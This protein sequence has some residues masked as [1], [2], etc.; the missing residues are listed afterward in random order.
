MPPE[1][2][3]INT[4]KQETNTDKKFDNLG[5]Q[6]IR[7]YKD[8]IQNVVQSE[9]ITSTRILLAE[10]RRQANEAYIKEDN[11][12]KSKKNSVML[13]ISLVLI[14]LTGGV[15]GFI[16]FYPKA[17]PEP[18]KI[19]INRPNFLEVDGQ[20]LIS[21]ELR[22]PRDIFSDLQRLMVAN[23]QE[24]TI[25]EVILSRTEK[26]T[27]DGE[28]VSSY[29]PI[30]TDEL[31][32]LLESR[33]PEAFARSV[34]KELMIGLYGTET[35]VEPYLLFK[36]KDFD[37]TFASMLDWEPSVSRDMQPIFFSNLRQEDLSHSRFEEVQIQQTSTSTSTPTTTPEVIKEQKLDFDP[38]IF[39]DKVVKNTDGR[40]LIND[41]G[42]IVFFYTFINDEYLMLG[43]SEK[44]LEEVIRRLRQSKLIR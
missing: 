16:W 29:R 34:D 31:L 11:S 23:I 30:I 36:I 3:K 8:D 27:V 20:T 26:K 21:T 33:S 15:L 12:L 35:G 6:N 22:N 9:N 17:A 44:V 32:K 39:K 42:E 18:S 41:S 5:I 38:T 7:T 4:N 25:E 13:M 14:T 1:D 19:L 24:D 10:Q 40:A 37:N 43:N 2:N 28:V